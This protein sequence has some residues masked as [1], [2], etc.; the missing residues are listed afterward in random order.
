MR[1]VVLEFKNWPFYDITLR[2]ILCSVAHASQSLI[3]STSICSQCLM[4]MCNICACAWP[5]LLPPWL[6]FESS[7]LKLSPAGVHV[8]GVGVA[9][10]HETMLSWVDVRGASTGSKGHQWMLVNGH[11]CTLTL[12]LVALGLAPMTSA[13]FS[14]GGG[15]RFRSNQRL[16]NACHHCNFFNLSYS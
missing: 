12:S 10:L 5:Y 2:F 14:N 16:C 4:T 8:R 3:T 7:W 9:R 6:S 1:R 13:T 11:S 15:R